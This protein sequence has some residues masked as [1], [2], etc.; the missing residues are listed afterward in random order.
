MCVPDL[1]QDGDEALVDGMLSHW[2]RTSPDRAAIVEGETRLRF[3]Q[4]EQSVAQRAAALVGARAP[5]SVL[6]ED[7]GSTTQRLVDFLGIVRSG[8]CAAVADR[9]W[10][11]V[12]RAQV[13]QALPAQPSN[14]CRAGGNSPFYIGYT[15]GSTGHPKGFMRDHRSWVESFR[16]CIETF[17]P[18]AGGSVLAPGGLSHSL[19][20]FGML[21]GLWT[22]GGVVVQPRF[23]GARA[24]SSLVRGEASCL[25]AVPSQLIMMLDQARRRSMPPI[26]SVRLVMISGA[27]WMRQHT[28]Q[29]RALFPKARLV[30]FYG[31]SETSFVAW[32][33]ADENAPASAVGK[34]FAN[35]EVDVRKQSD[36]DPAGMIFVRSPMLFS[37]YVGAENDGT[38]AVRDNDWLSVRDMGYLDEEGRLCLVGRQNRMI[39]TS[40]KNLFPGEVEAVLAT[41]PGVQA[42]SVQGVADPVR[43]RAVMALLHMEREPQSAAPDAASLIAWCRARLDA[44]KLPRRFLVCESWPLTPSG[45]TDHLALA[46]HV[47]AWSDKEDSSHLHAKPRPWLQALR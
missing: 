20:L 27:R 19:F 34:P 33:D 14:A 45:K 12:V 7:H 46:E 15:S 22:G 6:V 2:A 4:L 43:G 24:L 1:P 18:E 23:S 39:V 13:R 17:G 9:D 47:Q 25:V 32:M 28:P 38:A 29:L 8:R 44:Y 31:A 40:G 16:I 26:D 30:E 37:A 21:L 35:V 10:P 36:T 11:E 3:D 5:S 42:A 41:F